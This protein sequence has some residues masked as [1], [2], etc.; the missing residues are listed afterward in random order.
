MLQAPMLVFAFADIGLKPACPEST[1]RR[2]RRP[3]LDTVPGCL[4]CTT[5]ARREAG[6]RV[7]RGVTGVW[8]G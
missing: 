8:I 4:G 5:I 1:P 7:K 3:V 6:P 2:R